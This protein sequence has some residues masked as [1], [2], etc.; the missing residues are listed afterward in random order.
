MGELLT[1]D[2]FWIVFGFAGQAVFGGAFLIQWLASEKRKRSHIPV[3]FWWIRIAGSLMLLVWSG[4]IAMATWHETH[5]S[6][7]L[8]VAYSVNCV[9]Y[10]RNLVLIHRHKALV[11]AG[12]REPDKWEEA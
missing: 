1:S 11:A 7:V 3:S 12:V 8:I 5:Q 2:K 9:L 10:V 4:Q 6:M